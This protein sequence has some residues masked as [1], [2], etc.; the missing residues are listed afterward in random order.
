MPTSAEDLDAV[1]ELFREYVGAPGW[2]AGSQEYLALQA[3]DDELQRLR[4]RIVPA[5]LLLE[6]AT[7]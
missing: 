2:D 4:G 1:R 3:F 7:A 5:G 6:S